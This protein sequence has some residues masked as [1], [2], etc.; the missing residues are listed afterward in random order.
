V[1]ADKSLIRSAPVHCIDQ[2]GIDQ[3]DKTVF[4]KSYQ[5]QG[6]TIEE[7]ATHCSR[8]SIPRTC[9]MNV[10]KTPVVPYR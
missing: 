4:R 10:S 8:S 9:E 2:T 6:K 3:T 5:K 1:P 7:G